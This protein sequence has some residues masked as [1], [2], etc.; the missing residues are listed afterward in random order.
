MWDGNQW[1]YKTS[2]QDLLGTL[3]HCHSLDFL[4]PPTHFSH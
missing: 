2:S 3:P 4:A 1:K